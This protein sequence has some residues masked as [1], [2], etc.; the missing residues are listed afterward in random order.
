M[1]AIQPAALHVLHPITGVA[2]ADLSSL[3]TKTKQQLLTALQQRATPPHKDLS[4]DMHPP[5]TGNNAVLWVLELYA[6]QSYDPLDQ[7]PPAWDL[8]G[9]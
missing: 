7:K 9:M 8:P 2:V 6:S 1:S 4:P 5:M 3:P